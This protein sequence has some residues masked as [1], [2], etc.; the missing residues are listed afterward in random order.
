[1]AGALGEPKRHN[2]EF[3]VPNCLL[4]VILCTTCSST[5]IWWY[6]LWTSSLLNTQLLCNSSIISSFSNVGN[7][8]FTLM[9]F[10]A[11]NSIHARHSCVVSFLD[12]GRRGIWV[13]AMLDYWCRA[14]LGQFSQFP[15]VRNMGIC[16]GHVCMPASLHYMGKRWSSLVSRSGF[17]GLE[18][19]LYASITCRTE[20]GT[21][22]ESCWASTA[23]NCTRKQTCSFCGLMSSYLWLLESQEKCSWLVAIAAC[24]PANELIT[25]VSWSLMLTGFTWVNHWIPGT[26]SKLPT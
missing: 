9:L 13:L 16:R 17:R 6:L 11:C 21:W 14:F 22:W 24:H 2:N 25:H 7:L 26:A 19:F 12:E 20:E 8:I 1:M 15:S 5:K 18:T 3:I 4:N 23:A 10:G